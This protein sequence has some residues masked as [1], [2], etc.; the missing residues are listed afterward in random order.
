MEFRNMTKTERVDFLAET[1]RPAVL[2]IGSQLMCPV[3][4][5]P[6]L[7]LISFM[8]STQSRKALLLSNP[9]RELSLCVQ[10]YSESRVCYVTMYGTASLHS[11]AA[12]PSDL[13]RRIAGRYL[14]GEALEGFLAAGV[15]DLAVR[16]RPYKVVGKILEP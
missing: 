6:H 16:M 12:S 9:I 10:E 14:A 4:Y 7:P 3:W 13:P 1:G 2:A 5:L 8:T 15:D 11:L